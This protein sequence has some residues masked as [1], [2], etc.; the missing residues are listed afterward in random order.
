MGLDIKKILSL[1]GGIAATVSTGGLAAP[2]L[3]PAALNLASALI[4]EKDAKKIAAKQEI[5][6]LS[7]EKSA[8]CRYF[9]RRSSLTTKSLSGVRS[10]RLLDIC[11]WKESGSKSSV[12]WFSVA[13]TTEG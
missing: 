13:L 8:G 7:A 10:L 11:S 3:I 6:F 4:P 9:R 1:A 12:L 2:I 5:L